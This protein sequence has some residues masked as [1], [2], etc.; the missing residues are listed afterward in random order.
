MKL[1]IITV[2]IS[3]ICL[4]GCIASPGSEGH[5]ALPD[6]DT[7]ANDDNPDYADTLAAG[8]I[9]LSFEKNAEES[10]LSNGVELQI[11][12]PTKVTKASIEVW[13]NGK[14]L[15]SFNIVSSPENVV[16]TNDD[17]ENV[18]LS[19]EENAVRFN[20]LVTLYDDEI[21]TSISGNKYIKNSTSLKISKVSV[22]ISG[23]KDEI[24]SYITAGEKYTISSDSMFEWDKVDEY[25]I[26]NRQIQFNLE[27]S[28]YDRQIGDTIT[29]PLSPISGT[30]VLHFYYAITSSGGIKGYNIDSSFNSSYSSSYVPSR[31]V[32]GPSKNTPIATDSVTVT[33]NNETTTVGLYEF[34]DVDNN[35][36]R[37]VFL[38]DIDMYLD[39]DEGAGS[40]YDKFVTYSFSAQPQPDG[41]YGYY[42]NL[43]LNEGTLKERQ[44]TLARFNGEPFLYGIFNYL[45]TNDSGEVR[46]FS[47]DEDPASDFMMPIVDIY[48]SATFLYQGYTTVRTIPLTRVTTWNI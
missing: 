1:H 31:P 21:I 2:I 6:Y 41:G 4:V 47:D 20:L 28:Y 39:R 33:T 14:N 15:H 48:V 40:G 18:T 24:L 37:P 23:I 42:F 13:G 34:T 22:G 3:I 9:F 12:K 27:Y 17:H 10:V 43:I 45:G 16:I 35:F 5:G 30:P 19:Y 7:P 11:L 26:N 36:S 29:V 25:E 32:S 46:E 38:N 44:F 8:N